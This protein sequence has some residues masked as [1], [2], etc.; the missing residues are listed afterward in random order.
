MLCGNYLLSIFTSGII[1][2]MVA[3]DHRPHGW[4]RVLNVRDYG[5]EQYC[6]RSDKLSVVVELFVMEL[7]QGST[8][9]IPISAAKQ[10]CW[11][12]FWRL[13]V[14]V[15]CTWHISTLFL[16]WQRI[17]KASGIADRQRWPFNIRWAVG[18]FAIQQYFKKGGVQTTHIPSRLYSPKG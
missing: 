17:C 10:R 5:C 8:T 16:G 4:V 1:P 2:R 11:I 6:Y 18:L 7:V 9:T 13:W 14:P 3:S 15:Y 12:P